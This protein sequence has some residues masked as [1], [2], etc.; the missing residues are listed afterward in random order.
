MSIPFAPPLQP[1]GTRAASRRNLEPPRASTDL[2]C[3]G[4]KYGKNAC[5][6][7]SVP[8]RRRRENEEDPFDWRPVIPAEL[9][10]HVRHFVGNL[11]HDLRGSMQGFTIRSTDD[12]QTLARRLE[13]LSEE[14]ERKKRVSLAL[15]ELLNG[16]QMREDDED[17]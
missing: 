4:V 2:H 10:E 12:V 9:L 1:L 14:L 17:E 15:T 3:E 13:Q 8:K 16:F 6:L 5:G 7:P 11:P